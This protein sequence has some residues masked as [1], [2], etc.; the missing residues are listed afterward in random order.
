MVIDKALLDAVTLEATQTSRLR[1]NH[2][3]RNSSED[4]SQRMLNAI[5][6][7]TELPIHRHCN[8]SE[9]VIILRGK[10]EQLYYDNNGNITNR[11][12][13]EP[14]SDIVGLNIPKGAWH[15]IVSLEPGTVIFEAKDGAYEPVSPKDILAL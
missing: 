15:R 3:M 13:L 5:E 9:T 11:Y 10:A 7:G 1:M 14:N 6:P 2:D 8:S 12:I 4:N